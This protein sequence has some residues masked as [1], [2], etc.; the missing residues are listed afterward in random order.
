M[1]KIK[2]YILLLKKWNKKINLV[3]ANTIHTVM[4]RHIADSARIKDLIPNNYKVIDIGSGAGLPG[5]IL[6]IYGIENIELCEKNFKKAVFL[7]EVKRELGLSYDIYAEDIYKHPP[8]SNDN[9]V[10]VSRAFGSLD[11]LLDVMQKLNI[12]Y[13]IFHK[14]VTY[15]EEI[16]KALEKYSFKYEISDRN[17]NGVIVSVRWP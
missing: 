14:G 13:G 5:V 16:D 4:D 17:K 11:K 6:S 3:Q 1:D 12:N 7:R 2:Q 8:F 10:A 9:I 15:Q